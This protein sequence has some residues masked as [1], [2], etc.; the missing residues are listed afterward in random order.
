MTVEIQRDGPVTVITIQRPECRNAVDPPTA[1]RLYDAFVAFERDPAAAVAVLRGEGGHF[2]AGFDLKALARGTDWLRQVHFGQGSEVPP[3]G[4]M[5]PTRLSL[6]KPVIAAVAGA[7]VAGGMELAL[8]CDYRI[9][10]SSAYMGV[11]CRRWGV[12]LI[13]GGT[14]RLPR[15]VG[16]GRAR[17]LIL[18]GRRVD[19]DECL[20]I[21]LCEFVVPEGE[22]LA[23]AL[24]QAHDLAR[25][26]QHCL[27]ADRHCVEAQQ[28]LPPADALRQEWQWSAPV[29]QT[30]GVAG[31]GRFADGRGRH[32]A[33]DGS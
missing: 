12:P 4:P 5:G 32:G 33:F 27:R 14:V 20:R 10:E 22:A 13:D 29:V 28:G 24:T 16:L 3:L 6:R 18:S 9:L 2:S 1:C 11:F 25:F 19:A 23:T 30:E 15:L 31:A 26:P 21:G 7:A 17:E 8:W